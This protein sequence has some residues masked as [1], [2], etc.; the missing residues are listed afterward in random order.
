MNGFFTWLFRKLTSASTDAKIGQAFCWVGALLVMVA[1]MYKL[2]RLPLNEAEL[3]FGVL[4]VM[5]VTLLG[6]I[7]GLLLPVVE[8][9]ARKE[10][11]A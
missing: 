2:T 6:V 7:A 3:F 11:T 5:A 1:G 10:R 8:F 9:V 4:L